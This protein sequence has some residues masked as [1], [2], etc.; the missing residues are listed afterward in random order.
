MSFKDI[1]SKPL[2]S[3]AGVVLEGCESDESLKNGCC[4]KEGCK[5]ELSKKEACKKEGCKS[6]VCKEEAEDGIDTPIV[7]V[8]V[9]DDDNSFG[10]L[11]MD[12]DIDDDDLDAVDNVTG[13]DDELTPE[14][15]L[16]ADRIIDI[17]ATPIILKEE[18]G[19]DILKEFCSG[20]EFNTACNEGF[21]TE[22][23]ID[24]LLESVGDMFNDEV[25][26]EAKFFSKNKV[27]FTKEARMNQ[28]F[29]VCVQ[30]VA[31][32]KKDPIYFKLAKV[33]KLRRVLKA[34]LRQKYRAAAMK[35]AKEYLIRLKKS[36][37]N[38]I[39]DVAS[40]VFGK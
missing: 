21:L 36:R 5:H 37:S 6:E 22:S 28:L 15:D 38:I 16:E 9:V 23:S 34:Q 29:E 4:G 27:Q 25:Y 3:K 19:A 31:R 10:G 12:D 2:P 7:P 35:K 20:D 40:K 32:A 11:D 30:A 1:M 14:E 13:E 8:P 39:S 17:A 33:Q 26:T 24:M 18:L